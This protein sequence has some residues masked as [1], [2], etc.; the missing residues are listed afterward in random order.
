LAMRHD[1]PVSRPKPSTRL[2]LSCLVA[3]LGAAAAGCSDEGE[4]RSV[5]SC[6]EAMRDAAEAIEVDEQIRLLDAA[7]LSCGSHAAYVKELVA[8]PGLIGYSP[9]TFLEV[10][11]RA[12]T[13]PRLRRSP[14]CRAA[15]PPTTPP[16]VTAP[17]VVY[18]AATL[19]GRVIEMRPSAAVPFTGD[20][21][22]VVQETVDI[23]AA[24]NCPG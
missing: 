12:V 11:C 13:E 19:D 16:V 10:R 17:E 9:E 1:G 6:N 8:H 7:L 21:P 18:A 14:A 20:V 24:Q 2:L 4:A 3:V 5:P 15:N 23:A 22:A